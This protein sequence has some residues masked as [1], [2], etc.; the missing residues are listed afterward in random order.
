M[1][2]SKRKNFSRRSNNQRGAV[3]RP[4]QKDKVRKND[5]RR[6][7]VR[8]SLCSGR[9]RWKHLCALRAR[10][11]SSEKRRS[12]GSGRTND[13]RGSCKQILRGGH[14][15]YLRI[16]RGGI[17]EFSESRPRTGRLFSHSLPLVA[18]IRLSIPAGFGADCIIVTR[19]VSGQPTAF[20]IFESGELCPYIFPQISRLFSRFALALDSFHAAG[21]S[22]IFLPFGLAIFHIANVVKIKFYSLLFSLFSLQHP[23][24]E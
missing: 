21:K 16:C 4:P 6:K 14:W 20:F 24:F 9:N 7:T 12:T 19:A 17:K 5:S 2:K 22:C 18:P 3:E 1:K 23:L 13:Q 10:P 8:N 15:T 11:A